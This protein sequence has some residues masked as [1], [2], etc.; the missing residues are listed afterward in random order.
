MRGRDLG[1]RAE[2]HRR[3]QILA[4]RHSQ[5][6]AAARDSHCSSNTRALV[7]AAQHIM[8]ELPFMATEIILMEC[9]KAG[10]C[11]CVLGF[12]HAVLMSWLNLSSRQVLH[13]AIREHS[14]LA[15][16]RVKE[17]NS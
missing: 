14:M 13:E 15:A 9:V 4:A 12:I 5:G 2:C 17:A 10:G 16:R 7:C 8:E 11:V 6:A 3:T 1:H